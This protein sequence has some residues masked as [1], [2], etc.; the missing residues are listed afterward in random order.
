MTIIP[1]IINGK[2]LIIATPKKQ[3][4]ISKHISTLTRSSQSFAFIF[5]DL[6]LSP[7][8]YDEL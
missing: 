6:F 4:K 3:I 1:I 8:S 7:A 2:F 5:I